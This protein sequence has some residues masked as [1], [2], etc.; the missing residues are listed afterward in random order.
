M[1][2]NQVPMLVNIGEDVRYINANF[3]EHLP[4]TNNDVEFTT[5]DFDGEPI[6]QYTHEDVSPSTPCDEEKQ[7]FLQSVEEM[8]KKL[9]SMKIGLETMSVDELEHKLKIVKRCITSLNE[10]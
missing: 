4:T 6:P 3:G 10:P 5:T 8:V 9:D 2:T 1:T 7:L